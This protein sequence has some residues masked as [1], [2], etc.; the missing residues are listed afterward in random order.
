MAYKYITQN[1][2]MNI[3]ILIKLIIMAML[4][5]MLCACSSVKQWERGNLAKQEML[6]DPYPFHSKLRAQVF[7][8]KEGSS[9][10]QGASGGGCGCD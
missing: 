7:E 10:G 8:S 2:L 9:G 4:M 1:K 3:A 5:I 6:V